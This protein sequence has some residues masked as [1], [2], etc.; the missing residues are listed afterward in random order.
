MTV[1]G[2]G[3]LDAGANGS[4]IN[5]VS[6]GF[7]AGGQDSDLQLL[8]RVR[9]LGRRGL[10]PR[11]QERHQPIPRRRFRISSATTLWTRAISSRP[12]I[13]ELRYNDFGWDV[14]GPIKKNKLFFFVGRGVEATAAAVGAFAAPRCPPRRNC[15]AILSAPANHRR[16]RDQDA[17]S[18][19]HHPHVQITADGNAI[20]NI[21]RTVDPAGRHLHQ[22]GRSPTTP[23]LKIPIR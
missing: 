7:H 18:R 9:P 5:N 10:Q 12:I 23:P 2:V 6:P 21:Y 14:G 8:R 16:A 15:R 11:D 20:A 4:L 3:N 1:D 17:V 13:T 22:H 19:Q